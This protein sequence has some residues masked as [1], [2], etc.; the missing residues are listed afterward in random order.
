MAPASGSPLSSGAN[1]GNPAFTP[2]TCSGHIFAAHQQPKSGVPSK[3]GVS[4]VTSQSIM[5]TIG[6]IASHRDV[7]EIIVDRTTLIYFGDCSAI[8]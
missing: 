5:A 8:D 4:G 3:A 1:L 6:E 7:G 2:A